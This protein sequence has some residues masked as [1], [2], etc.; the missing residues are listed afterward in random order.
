MGQAHTT[1]ARASSSA[2]ATA[3]AAA[4]ESHFRVVPLSKEQ[5]ARQKQHLKEKVLDDGMVQCSCGYIALDQHHYNLHIECHCPGLEPLDPSGWPQRHFET[6][7]YVANTQRGV[8]SKGNIPHAAFTTFTLASDVDEASVR[9]AIAS[10]PQLA[11]AVGTVDETAQVSALVAVSSSLWTKWDLSPPKEL[12]PFT[13]LKN[14]EEE[15]LLPAM[16]GSELFLMVKAK[17][18]DLCYEVTKRFRTMLSRNIASWSTTLGF[19]YMPQHPY[20]GRDLTGFVDGT[21]NPDHL[22]RSLVDEVVIFPDDY[23]NDEAHT[24]GTYMFA[25]RFV[26]NLAKF[27][28]M[29][30]KDKNEVIGRDYE[31]VRP[32]HGYD[33]RPENPRLGGDDE[34]VTVENTPPRSHSARA[35]GSMLRQAYP[36]CNGEEEGLYFTAYS[37]F[38]SEID[39]ALKRMCGHFAEDGSVDNLFSITRAV[40]CNYYYVPSLPELKWLMEI[41]DEEHEKEKETGEDEGEENDE[42]T[43]QTKDKDKQDEESEKTDIKVIVEYCTNCG[44]KTI[45]MEKKKIMESVSPR[46]KVIG[47]PNMPRLAAFEITLEDG[48]ILWSKLSHHDGRNNFPHVFPSNEKL[49]QALEEHVGSAGV[50]RLKIEPIG[51]IYK[52]G[53]R[54]GVW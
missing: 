7:P 11:D 54:V 1:E 35:F 44:Y 41:A 19:A 34:Y 21:R 16:T 9:K 36:Y 50:E 38:L 45:F 40:G 33:D 46:V 20:G 18:V 22:L 37:R 26:H 12:K 2:S 48:T 24:G 39:T 5:L 23:E 28:A 8:V 49:V 32:H 31:K 30:S 13:D 4:T 14:S 52:A 6:V 43:T 53:T 29:S 10:V 17:R 25:G 27:F 42:T 47:N 15:V 51:D 3:P